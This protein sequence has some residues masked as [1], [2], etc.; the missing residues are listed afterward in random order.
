MIRNL[1]SLLFT[2]VFI[3]LFAQQQSFYEHYTGLISKELKIT[4]DLIRSGSAFS[5]YYYYEF[6][7]EGHWISSKAIALDGHIDEQENFVLNEFGGQTSYFSG[8]LESKKLIKGVW[9]NQMLSDEVDFALKA[10]YPEGS[11]PL[12]LASHYQKKNFQNNHKMPPA[13]L[14]LSLLFPTSGLESNVYKDLLSEIYKYIGFRGDKQNKSNVLNE[15]AQKYDEQFQSSLASVK[16]DSFPNSF[17]WQKSIRMDVMNN[18]HHLLCLQFENYA[19]TGVREGTQVKKYLIYDLVNNRKIHLEN[20]FKPT[21]LDQ[22]SQLLNQKLR[23]QYHISSDSS[24]KDF[25]FFVDELQPNKNI[26]LHPGGIG[27]YYNVFEIAPFSNGATNIFLPWK[28]LEK[29]FQIP[30]EIRKLYN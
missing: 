10:T 2:L 22:L 7:E 18:E 13:E 23:E 9:V 17:N 25:G 29:Q 6:Q 1:L 24:L 30:A 12:S 5:G 27:F 15:I 14:S 3:P 8:Q 4:A 21:D 28:E 11:I 16:L 26:Y 20:I 19:K